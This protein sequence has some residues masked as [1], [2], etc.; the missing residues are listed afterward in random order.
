MLDK[1]YAASSSV[2]RMCSE[3]IRATASAAF[4]SIVCLFD[5][6]TL[7]AD[8][9]HAI[10]AAPKGTAGLHIALILQVES[11]SSP[12]D[13]SS[14]LDSSPQEDAAAAAIV[15]RLSDVNPRRVLTHAIIK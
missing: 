3:Q 2:R 10:L 11:I 12:E 15:G 13:S 5:F 1:L 7:T 9:S 6:N 8:Q 14:S 4:W